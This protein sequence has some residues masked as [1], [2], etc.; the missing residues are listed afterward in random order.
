[1]EAK[2]IVI[3]KSLFDKEIKSNTKC[4]WYLT[5]TDIILG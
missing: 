1:M 3:I 4:T 5:F 2:Y